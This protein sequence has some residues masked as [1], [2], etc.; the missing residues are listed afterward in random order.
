[1]IPNGIHFRHNFIEIY[2]TLLGLF[3]L[4]PV[5]IYGRSDERKNVAST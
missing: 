4:V 1:M 5:L 3:S 2:Y